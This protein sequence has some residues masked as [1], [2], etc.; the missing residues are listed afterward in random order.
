MTTSC[1]CLELMVSGSASLPSRMDGGKDRSLPFQEPE[2]TG[3][4]DRLD[5]VSLAEPR[6]YAMAVFTPGDTPNTSTQ[7]PATGTNAGSSG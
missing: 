5:D 2:L 3:P 7:R 6:D 4:R 1:S